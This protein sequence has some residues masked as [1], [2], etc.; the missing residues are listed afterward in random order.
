MTIDTIKFVRKPIYVDGVQV[1]SENFSEVAEWCGGDI[2]NVDDSPLAYMGDLP[3]IKPS[4][5]YIRVRVYNPRVARHSMAFVGDWLLYTDRGY[6][7]YTDRAL[8]NTFDEVPVDPITLER[9]MPLGLDG[10]TQ[11]TGPIEE[12]E[13]PPRERATAGPT[14]A[15]IEEVYDEKAPPR[16]P[17]D[18][19]RTGYVVKDEVDDGE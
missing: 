12:G 2:T 1:T 13:A 4:N 19:E 14:R 7:V 3:K 18:R 16:D 11:T 10:T 5:Q 6:K 8:K 9:T 15:D 17:D